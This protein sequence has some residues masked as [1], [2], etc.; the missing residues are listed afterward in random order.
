[1]FLGLFLVFLAL[2]GGEG[3]GGQGE[4]SGGCR[5]GV[6]IIYS[7]W[8]PETPDPARVL[9]TVALRISGSTG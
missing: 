3:G 7:V 8:K 1:L 4:G 9:L 5:D 6:S 2:D